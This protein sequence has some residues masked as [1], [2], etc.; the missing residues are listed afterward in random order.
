VDEPTRN[1]QQVVADEILNEIKRLYT[2][3][4]EYGRKGILRRVRLERRAERA[5][6]R[7]DGAAPA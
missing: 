6:S 3:L 7:A 5:A 1:Q 2:G 4:Q